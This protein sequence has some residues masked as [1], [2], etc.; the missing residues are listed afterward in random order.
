MSRTALWFAGLAAF[1]GSVY[2]LMNT[3]LLAGSSLM[4]AS[5]LCGGMAETRATRQRRRRAYE[6]KY[7]ASWEQ[8]RA[9][10]DVHAVRRMRDE[11]G[12]VQAVRM[13]RREVPEVPLKDA[14]RLVQSL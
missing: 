14:V 3:A 12:D 4:L 7:G 10:V 11:K 2:L 8:V 1:A 5:S 13:V 9:G 6:E